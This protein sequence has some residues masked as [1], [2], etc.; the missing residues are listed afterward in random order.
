MLKQSG[1]QGPNMTNKWRIIL[2]IFAFVCSV[3][4]ILNY[5]VSH[6]LSRYVY[7][8]NVLRDT[9][10][11]IRQMECPFPNG[12][13]LPNDERSISQNVVLIY[14]PVQGMRKIMI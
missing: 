7:Q 11:T 5:N 9:S 10:L 3:I 2:I 14:I 6:A 4:I 8:S 1:K 12:F 13:H